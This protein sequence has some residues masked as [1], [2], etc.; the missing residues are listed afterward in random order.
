MYKKKRREEPMTRAEREILK[1]KKMLNNICKECGRERHIP[2]AMCR[3]C[4][5]ELSETI[6]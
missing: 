5:K 1:R 2:V 6:N 4:W 3:E